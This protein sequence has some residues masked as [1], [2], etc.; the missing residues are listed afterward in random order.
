VFYWIFVNIVQYTVNV[1]STLS[2]IVLLKLLI[3]K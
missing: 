2:C 1:D 3:T